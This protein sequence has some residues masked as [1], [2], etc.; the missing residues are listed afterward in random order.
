MSDPVLVGEL[1]PGVLGEVIDR[2]GHGY[3][4]WV[5]EG[6]VLAAQP[7]LCEGDD[8]HD[9]ADAAQGGGQRGVPA[10]LVWRGGRL[11]AQVVRCWALATLGQ[12]HPAPH[13]R[14]QQLAN[15]KRHHDGAHAP[16]MPAGPWADTCPSGGAA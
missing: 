12:P 6:I 11:L 13:Q 8:A 14:Q 4:R 2:A 16:S 3:Q 9:Q 15:P 1:L 10:L 7:G 5:G